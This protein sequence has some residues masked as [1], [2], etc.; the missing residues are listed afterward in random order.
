MMAL[1]C[2][3]G[4]LGG[5]GVW[6]E[7]R[8]DFSY[9][10]DAEEGCE[11]GAVVGDVFVFVWEVVVRGVLGGLEEGMVDGLLT[12]MGGVLPQACMMPPRKI[13]M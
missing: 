9:D 13:G 10:G 11:A 1:D 5:E 6:G 7:G 2:A 12:L 3:E 4:A 8:G